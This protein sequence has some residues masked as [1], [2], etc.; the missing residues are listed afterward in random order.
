MI[1]PGKKI[2]PDS[3][4][5][6]FQ[7]ACANFADDVARNLAANGFIGFAAVGSN[8]APV[9]VL[10]VA[11]HPGRTLFQKLVEIAPTLPEYQQMLDEVERLSQ[12][13]RA[14]AEGN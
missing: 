6:M 10:V 11:G 7:D 14:E 2:N 13:I 12:K 3:L 1:R 5:E 9:D 4:P 8:I